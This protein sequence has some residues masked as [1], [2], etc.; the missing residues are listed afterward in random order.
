MA[1]IG[2]AHG[3]RGEVRVKAFTADPLALAEYGS[4]TAEDGRTFRVERLRPAKEVVIAKLSGVNDRTAAEALNGVELY[5]PR[6]KLPPPDDDD[7]FYHADLIGLEAF[8]ADGEPLG[9][10][11]AVHNFGA[12]DI[13]DIAPRRGP[14][15]LIPFTREAVPDIELSMGRL[16]AIPPPD[17]PDDE[18]APNAPSQEEA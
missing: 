14:S 1:R 16:V 6:D 17:A 11:V 9:T 18:D 12:G 10:V 2:A 3:V 5:V 7:D 15:L 4:L 13:L 8:G